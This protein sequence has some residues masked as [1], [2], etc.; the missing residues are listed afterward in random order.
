MTGWRRQNKLRKRYGGKPV[1]AS[2]NGERRYLATI[3]GLSAPAAVWATT[4]EKAERK[5][6]E[7]ARRYG[8]TLLRVTE[9]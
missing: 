8:A 2:P 5:A 1:K 9:G 4:Q 7:L 3:S 6:L